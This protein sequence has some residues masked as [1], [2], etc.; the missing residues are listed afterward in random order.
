[1]NFA[2]GSRAPASLVK[3]SFLH[4]TNSIPAKTTSNS[5]ENGCAQGCCKFRHPANPKH[6]WTPLSSLLSLCGLKAALQPPIVLGRRFH[7]RT[8]LSLEIVQIH[9]IDSIV[10]LAVRA[11]LGIGGN[12]LQP[13]QLH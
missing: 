11:N 2:N 3:A 8:D 12:D 9:S 7:P 10:R 4:W 5:A 13:F 6:L 1:M